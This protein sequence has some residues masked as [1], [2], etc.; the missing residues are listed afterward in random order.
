MLFRSKYTSDL[1]S[2]LKASFYTGC[3]NT[4]AT[5]YDGYPVVQIFAT[6]PNTLVVNKAGRP[7]SEP[8][9]EIE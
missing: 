7:A 8:I 1:S 2:G 5:T 4:D 9:L 3:K 6:N